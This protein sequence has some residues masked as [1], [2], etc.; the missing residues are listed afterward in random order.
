MLAARSPTA[1]MHLESSNPSASSSSLSQEANMD[2]D[3]TADFNDSS[4]G[5]SEEEGGIFFGSHT[6]AESRFLAKL[7]GQPSE[8]SPPP[9]KR[10]QSRLVSM[11]R[12]DSTEFNR[13]KTMVYPLPEMEEEEKERSS[14][15]RI[16]D[17]YQQE[18][19]LLQ[20]SPSALRQTSPEA[21]RNPLLNAFASMHLAPSTTVKPTD[22]VSESDSDISSDSGHSESDKENMEV[23]V[24]D[25]GEQVEEQHPDLLEL[26]VT[27]GM[28]DSVE[29][30]FTNGEFI[31]LVATDIRHRA[32]PWWHEV[33]GFRRPG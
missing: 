21:S 30:E 32:R 11:L 19:S 13:R 3:R 23:P 4:D 14:D 12:R 26:S 27:R 25:S 5:S 15:D 2:A 8:P 9:Q 16:Q 1:L 22:E 33:V 17:R 10:R 28:R 18:I 6:D 24:E 31:T 20:L 29:D 7:S